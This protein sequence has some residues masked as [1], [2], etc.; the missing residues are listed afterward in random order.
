MHDLPFGMHTGIGSTGTACFN[1]LIR[2]LGQ[3]V[4]N[5][6]LDAHT[7]ALTLPAVIGRAVVLDAERYAKNFFV[8]A[9]A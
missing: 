6:A 5:E 1:W 8:G 3:G 7:I 9:Y 2:H 4:F